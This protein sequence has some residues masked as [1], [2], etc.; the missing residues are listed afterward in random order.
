MQAMIKGVFTVSDN[1][2]QSVKMRLTRCMHEET[3]LP[4]GMCNV[5][6]GKDK[7]LESPS[8][9]SVESGIGHRRPV[10]GTK[11]GI[12]VNRSGNRF[13]MGHISTLD[14][15]LSILFLTKKHTV[16]VTLH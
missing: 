4:D 8:K 1:T 10:R 12:H 2:L 14:D 13:A 9:A 11:L 3:H 16:G 5:S 6:A 15:I 7:V